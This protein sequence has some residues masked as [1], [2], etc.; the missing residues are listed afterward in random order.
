MTTNVDPAGISEE[1]RAELLALIEDAESG[2]APGPGDDPT[3][4]AQPQRIAAVGPKVR[5]GDGTPMH[6]SARLVAVIVMVE[7]TASFAII[8][9]AITSSFVARAEREHAPPGDAQAALEALNARF[10][11]LTF[12]LDRL[13]SMVREEKT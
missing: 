2:R 11:E 6:A 13:E 10:H 12:R 3:A 4:K 8:T 1:T 5:G 7:A 9:A